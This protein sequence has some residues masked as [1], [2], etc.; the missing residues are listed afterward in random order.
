[1]THTRDGYVYTSSLIAEVKNHI[2]D[3]VIP[4]QGKAFY[5]FD[6]DDAE[7]HLSQVELP[8]IA[9]MYVSMSPYDGQS[10]ANPAKDFSGSS[11]VMQELMISVIV[12]D[13]YAGAGLDNDANDVTKHSITD[14]LDD[15]RH[16]MLGYRGVNSRPWQW[17]GE[18]P[19]ETSL[20]N[21][22]MYAQQW[23]T[24]VAL[25]KNPSN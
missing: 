23:R 25:R 13:E 18:S 1:M 16:A 15:T 11:A 10:G 5:V 12:V 14:L 7:A 4:L 22:V 3:S 9:I 20:Q 6:Q 8:F 21:A 19:L 17:I 24:L 2:A